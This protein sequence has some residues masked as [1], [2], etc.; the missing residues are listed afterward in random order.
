MRVVVME[1]LHEI[2]EKDNMYVKVIK[3]SSVVKNAV[4]LL[5]SGGRRR[6]TERKETEGEEEGEGKEEGGDGITGMKEDSELRIG[7]K[8]KLL[9]LLLLLV[10][11]GIEISEEEE[12]MEVV[13]RL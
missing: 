4:K 5:E 12:L 11:R 3:E 13:L 2:C 9:E 8:I 6:Q 1:T 7:E 10:K